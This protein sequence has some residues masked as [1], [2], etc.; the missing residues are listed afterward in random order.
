MPYRLRACDALQWTAAIRHAGW[1][2]FVGRLDDKIRRV[3][4]CQSENN[5][6]AGNPR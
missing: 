6:S 1:P 3:E 4:L 5:R 2:T